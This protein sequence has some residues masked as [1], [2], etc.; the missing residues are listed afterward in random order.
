MTREEMLK[1]PR[2]VECSGCG[3]LFLAEGWRA[4]NSC[5]ETCD[6]ENLSHA[7]RVRQEYELLDMLEH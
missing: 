2:C 4:D 7:E 6:S 3:K 5:C 1:H